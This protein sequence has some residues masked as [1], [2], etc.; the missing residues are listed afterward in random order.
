MQFINCKNIFWLQVTQY[1]AETRSGLLGMVKLTQAQDDILVQVH[2]H[3]S[4]VPHLAKPVF[5]SFKSCLTSAMA[6]NWF[7]Q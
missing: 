5:L 6:G 7:M 2:F 3:F 1:L 4:D